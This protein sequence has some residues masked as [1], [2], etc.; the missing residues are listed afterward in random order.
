MRPF[1]SLVRRIEVYRFSCAMTG[2]RVR[3]NNG[4]CQMSRRTGQTDPERKFAMGRDQEFR[5]AP[6][7]SNGAYA[8]FAPLLAG[9]RLV[10]HLNGQMRQ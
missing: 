9:S 3:A 4:H 6:F 10:R 8:A 7:N 2:R 5:K 1:A